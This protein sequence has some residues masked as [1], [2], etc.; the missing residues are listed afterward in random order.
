M[1]RN[2][3]SRRKR[4][5][6]RYADHRELINR[7]KAGPCE[8]CGGQFNPWQMHFDHK[9]R[10]LKKF[11]ISCLAGKSGF[12]WKLEEELKKCRLLCANCHA[13]QTYKNKH[14]RHVEKSAPDSKQEELF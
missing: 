1:N 9:E 4:Y 6:K 12:A 10:S 11:N 5:K 7:L 3:P 13:D 14:W 8:L 2:P